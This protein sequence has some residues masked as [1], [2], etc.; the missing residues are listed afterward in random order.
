M[1]FGLKEY[2]H[3]KGFASYKYI[4][5]TLHI[6]LIFCTFHKY[7]EFSKAM[8][9]SGKVFFNNSNFFTNETFIDENYNSTETLIY[10][11]S[12]GAHFN[13]KNGTSVDKTP[14][15]QTIMDYRYIQLCFLSNII[16]Q[17]II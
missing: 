10:Q 9:I 17:H 16:N 4:M 14:I 12:S 3:I 15:W 7:C 5:K 6:L 11:N 8:Q 13:L 2:M 1:M